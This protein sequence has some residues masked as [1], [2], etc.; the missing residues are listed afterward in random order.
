MT[1]A[2][3]VCARMVMDMCEVLFLAGSVWV[4]RELARMGVNGACQFGLGLLVLL[5][6]SVAV[7]S[8]GA[9]GTDAMSW[10]WL[11]GAVFSFVFLYVLYHMGVLISACRR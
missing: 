2:E 11:T 10:T 6:L 9:L 7:S 8:V 5:R 4:W 1:P 3:G